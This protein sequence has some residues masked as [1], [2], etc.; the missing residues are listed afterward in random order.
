MRENLPANGDGQTEI[1]YG[2]TL[3]AAPTT[4]YIVFG[5]APPAGCSGT[6]ASPQASRGNLCVFEGDTAI[7]ATGRVFD[8]VSGNNN[9]SSTFGAGVAMTAIAAGDT[10]VRGS[11]AV[12]AP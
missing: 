12:T 3:L 6:P 2:F 10:R 8:P 9:E 1:E 7:N 5:T 11:W 4:H